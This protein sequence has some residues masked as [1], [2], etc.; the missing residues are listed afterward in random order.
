[1]C[2]DEESSP[3]IETTDA[4]ILFISGL[5]TFTWHIFVVFTAPQMKQNMTFMECFSPFLR[6]SFST[7]LFQ[8]EEKKP[9]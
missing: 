2:L 9:S 1:M 7:S 5:T 6:N 4:L 8:N 3:A